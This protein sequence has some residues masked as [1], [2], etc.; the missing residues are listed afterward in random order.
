MNNKTKNII[1]VCLIGVMFFSISFWCW[2]KKEDTY[3]ESE[4]RVLASFPELTV[5]SFFNGKFMKDF[6]AYTQDQFPMRD[7]FRSVQS[8][9][10]YY[11][12]GHRENNDI[13]LADGHV[14]KIEYPLSYDMLD[15]AAE[16]FEYINN[17]Y[18]SGTDVNTYF[19][20]VPDKNYFLAEQNGYLSLDYEELTSYMQSKTEYMNYIDVTDTLSL[21]DYY[22][23]DTH[24]RQ[25]KI[26]DTAERLASEMGAELGGEYNVNTLD[27]PFY[28][29]Y[30]GQAALPLEPDTIRYLTN[31]VINSC[32][33][34]S[35]DTGSPVQKEMYD[36]KDAY[37]K[38]PYEMFLSGAEALMVIENPNA[39]TDKELVIFRDSFG[40]S[41]APLLAEGYSKI[42]LVDIRYIQSSLIGNFIDFTNQDVLFLYSTILL[43]N[44]LAFK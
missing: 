25:E 33:V 20:I 31:D 42:T 4:R 44:S 8:M 13:F 12:L 29:V 5:E 7:N 41:I 38:D 28:G 14:S 15:H 22:Y 18:L 40:S 39:A 27:N 1:V 26:F 37:G 9:I 35:Y 23:T 30:C 10:A 19:S 2:F 6:E 11:L 32:I 34:T 21:D 17:T 16:R 43:N 24:W 36:M 3:S